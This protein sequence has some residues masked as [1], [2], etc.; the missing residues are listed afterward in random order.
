MSTVSDIFALS[1]IDVRPDDNF[2]RACIDLIEPFE[3]FNGQ[4]V[5]TQFYFESRERRTLDFTYNVGYPAA[6]AINAYFFLNVGDAQKLINPVVIGQPIPL[7]NPQV[8]APDD[9][10]RL[11]Q[12]GTLQITAPEAI[13]GENTHYWGALVIYQSDTAEGA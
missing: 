5:E 11:E 2:I 4:R 1:V 10:G 8:P 3:I 9:T 13:E 7:V 12:E 6:H